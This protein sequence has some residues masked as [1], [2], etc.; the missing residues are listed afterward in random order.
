MMFVLCACN[1]NDK[2]DTAQEPQTY[3]IQYSDDIGIH[4]I[5]VKSGA[6]YSIN[7]VP[8]RIGYDFIGLFDSEVGGVQYINS[9]GGSLATFSDNKNLVLYPQ[10]KAKR[11]T[12]VLDY[13]GA[14]VL[15]ARSLPVTYEQ[16][17]VE[18]PMNLTMENKTFCGWYTA[19]NRGGLQIADQYGVIPN[20]AKITE[21]NFDLTNPD[22]FIN[23]YAGF[24]GQEYKV[25][26]YIDGVREPEEQ[27]IEHGTHISQVVTQTRN[28]EGKAVFSWSKQSDKAEV[29]EGRIV[30][31]MV[32]YSVDFAPAIDF[33]S[34][35]GSVVASI[36]A[37]EGDSI[38][39]P[40]PVRT[41]Y[42]FAGWYASDGVEYTTNTMPANSIQLVARW[43]AQLNFN[44]NGGG[45]VETIS[46]PVGTA[47]ELPLAEKSGFIFAGWYDESGK[48]YNST[49]M[50]QK[51]RTLYAKYYKAESKRY[52]MIDASTN[53][54]IYTVEP[55]TS[56]YCTVLD[57]S[58]LYDAGIRNINVKANYKG[59][60]AWNH[61]RL[62]DYAFISMNW[63]KQSPASDGYKVWSYR[64]KINQNDKSAYRFEH[65]TTLTLTTSKYYVSRYCSYYN[66]GGFG[67]STCGWISD[68]WVEVSYPDMS[69]LY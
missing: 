46:Q 4:T 45:V 65:S 52:V 37:R 17:L 36:I 53:A 38:V 5:S 29:F 51:S 43:N 64:D 69:T 9:K 61:S 27:M 41:N 59:W 60:Y 66:S 30:D 23:L 18:L 1:G 24:K 62:P 44:T 58:E 28:K 19:P 7:P 32:L 10:F 40:T 55:S 35:D 31:S 50:P 56:R 12:L 20:N 16:T 3:T 67:D 57:L 49:S 33:D 54:G 42:T 47:I 2:N 34:N 68:F 11:Y 48:A 15:G 25:T 63:Y 22:G 14:A 13:Q 6:L 39:L 21:T 26:F 8:S